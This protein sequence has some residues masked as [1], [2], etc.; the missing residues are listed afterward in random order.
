M[1]QAHWKISLSPRLMTWILAFM[2]FLVLVM[3]YLPWIPNFFIG[4]LLI[5]GAYDL[6][7]LFQF[8]QGLSLVKK[9]EGGWLLVTPEKEEQVELLPSSFCSTW[10]LLF[11]LYTPLT[12]KK[13]FLI[14]SR[15]ILASAE[16]SRLRKAM[17]FKVD[18]KNQRYLSEN[19]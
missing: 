13:I 17:K 9:A 8:Y 11:H 4:F 2:L 10:I 16:W 18:C 15:D 14:V 5:I 7:K 19:A 6:L 1:L 3:F 12:N